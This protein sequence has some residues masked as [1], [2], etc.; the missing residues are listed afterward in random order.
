[1]GVPPPL[2][3]RNSAP[4]GVVVT[5]AASTVASLTS[6]GSGSPYVMHAKTFSTGTTNGAES[7]ANIGVAATECTAQH[8]AHMEMRVV[9]RAV[10]TAPAVHRSPPS[11][12]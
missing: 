8:T 12:R 9:A 11:P 3:A 2:C 1:M 7:V 4:R 10:H 5:Q 6:V